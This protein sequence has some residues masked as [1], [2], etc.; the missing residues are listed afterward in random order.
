MH[1]DSIFTDRVAEMEYAWLPW[2][3]TQKI[4]R[5]RL[6]W[7]KGLT[8]SKW[9]V[10][11]RKAMHPDFMMCDGVCSSSCIEKCEC[12]NE[13]IPR[14]HALATSHWQRYVSDQNTVAKYRPCSSTFLGIVHFAHCPKFLAGQGHLC[15]KIF[16]AG[17]RWTVHVKQH[18]HNRTKTS[19]TD[20]SKASVVRFAMLPPRRAAVWA[21]KLRV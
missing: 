11:Q 6:L 12:A 21:A 2:K 17:I 19:R 1:F 18:S 8:I 20:G 15:R 3:M 10:R 13:R 7:R 14:R 9:C 5:K 4:F 16:P